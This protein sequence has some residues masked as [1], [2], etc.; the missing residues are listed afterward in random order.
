MKNLIKAIFEPWNVEKEDILNI[1]FGLVI[2]AFLVVIISN[3]M[4]KSPGVLNFMVSIILV[5]PLMLGACAIFAGIDRLFTEIFKGKATFTMLYKMTFIV[6][7]LIVV[8]NILNFI[9]PI[10]L[11]QSLFTIAVLIYI[12]ICRVNLL[13]K[14]NEY[15]IWKAVVT[16]SVPVLLM[17]PPVMLLLMANILMPNFKS[18]RPAYESYER[19]ETIEREENVET[20]FKGFSYMTLEDVDLS[21]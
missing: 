7:I 16:T 10:Q 19:M 4:I 6:W 8:L 3:I 20:N 14:L 1:S 2:P 21:E 18:Y 13:A 11:V 5:F 15:E 9:I 17:V 12:F